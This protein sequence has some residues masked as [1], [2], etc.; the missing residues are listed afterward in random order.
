LKKDK[1]FK[2]TIGCCQA[3]YT[4]DNV[5]DGFTRSHHDEFMWKTLWYVRQQIS[6]SWGEINTEIHTQ[7][8]QINQRKMQSLT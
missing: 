7:H 5:K 1:S 4:P 8:L 3:Q 6:S 2:L